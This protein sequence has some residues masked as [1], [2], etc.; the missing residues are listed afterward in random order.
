MFDVILS[1]SIK[2]FS[3]DMRQNRRG[4]YLQLLFLDVIPRYNG[5]QSTKM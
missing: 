2:A 4:W 3:Y 1:R 5:N